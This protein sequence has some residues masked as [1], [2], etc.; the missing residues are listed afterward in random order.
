MY[1]HINTYVHIYIY[2]TDNVPPFTSSIFQEFLYTW[3]MKHKLSSV[4]YPQSN[5]QAEH[6]VKTSKRIINGKIGPQVSLNNDNVTWAILHYRNTSIQGIGLSL[7][8]LLLHHQLCDS[9]PSQS[10]IYKP[11]LKWVVAAQCYK[12]ILHHHNVKIIA[13]YNKYTHILSLQAG[14]SGAIQRPLNHWWN[15]MGKIITVLQNYQY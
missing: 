2:S 11:H 12:E 13:K 5:V 7:V 14:D 10:I 8:Q 4:E 15:T 6:V 9:I 1:I 3:C